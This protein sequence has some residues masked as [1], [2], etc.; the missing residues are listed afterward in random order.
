MKI[1]NF[2]QS[3]RRGRGHKNLVG[4]GVIWEL[5]YGHTQ[6]FPIDSRRKEKNKTIKKCEKC[7]IDFIGQK[8]CKPCGAQPTKYI[9]YS[10]PFWCV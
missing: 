6:A 7:G 10:K 9:S 8:F 2:G 5:I 4:R 1:T 3:E